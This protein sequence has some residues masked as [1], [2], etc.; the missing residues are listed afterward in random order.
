M[1]DN[2]YNNYPINPINGYVNV[3]PYDNDDDYMVDDTN[4]A[5]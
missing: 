2:D 3:S 4:L 5:N 1:Y